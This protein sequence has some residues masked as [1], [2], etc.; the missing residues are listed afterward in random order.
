MNYRVCSFFDG[1][2]VRGMRVIDI[3]VIHEKTITPLT[4]I[5]RYRASLIT[6][7]TRTLGRAGTV[8]VAHNVLDGEG[9]PR[10]A[11]GCSIVVRWS[12]FS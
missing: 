12:H 8:K 2:A 10:V 3:R 7:I 5:Y 11:R 1:R 6:G 4:G 9:G